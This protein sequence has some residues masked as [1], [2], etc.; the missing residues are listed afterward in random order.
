MI[1]TLFKIWDMIQ[2][3]H[4]Q[5]EDYRNNMT[6]VPCGKNIGYLLVSKTCD[7][8]LLAEKDFGG[9]CNTIVDN[10]LYMRF[11]SVKL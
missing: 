6:Q 4:D 8:R 7:L 3:N 11:Q 10:K 1:H 9:R 5:S 2:E